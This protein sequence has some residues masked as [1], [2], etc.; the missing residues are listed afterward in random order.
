M[1]HVCAREAIVCN[2]EQAL[3]HV[4]PLEEMVAQLMAQVGGM[5]RQ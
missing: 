3:P 5:A 2:L 1:L 4:R